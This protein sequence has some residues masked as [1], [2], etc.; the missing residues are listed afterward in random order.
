MLCKGR[1]A[2]FLQ[3][4]VGQPWK[5]G[6]HTL[7]ALLCPTVPPV[8]APPP[9]GLIRIAEEPAEMPLQSGSSR[10]RCR[11]LPSALLL[12]AALRGALLASQ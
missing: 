4:P 8:N 5:G 11:S 10:S 7:Q 3:H 1:A 9:L 6:L 12:A 2:L